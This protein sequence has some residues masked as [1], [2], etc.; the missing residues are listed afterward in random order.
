VV[1]C[2]KNSGDSMPTKHQKTFNRWLKRCW[3]GKL[4]SND[5]KRR[6]SSVY[7]GV[8]AKFVEYS[9]LQE[10]LYKHD[11]G[12]FKAGDSFVQS[13]HKVGHGKRA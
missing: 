4:K 12:N 3:E 5:T 6:R 8:K 10:Q 13:V 2:S 11:D 9:E 1:L 7:D